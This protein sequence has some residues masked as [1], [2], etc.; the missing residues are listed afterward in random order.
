VN[1]PLVIELPLCAV[2]LVVAVPVTFLFM[3]VLLAV[4]RKS[5][6][7]PQSGER[8]RLAILM[9]AHNE[10]LLV[11]SSIG[12]ILPQLGR[13]DRLVVVADNCSDDTAAIAKSAGAEVLVRTD[14]SH[15]GKGYALDYG[16]RHLE[17]DPPD[18]VIIVDA[19]CQAA[20]GCVDRLARLCSRTGRPIQALYLMRAPTGSRIKARVAEFAWAVINQIRPTGLNR[21]GLPC[22]LMGSGMAFPWACISRAAVAS[23]HLVEDRILGIDLARGGFPPLFCPDALV[24]SYFPVSKEGTRSQR[25]RWEH[26]SLGNIVGIALPLFLRSLFPFNANLMAMALDMAVPPLALLT[27]QVVAIW[28]AAALYFAFTGLL[29]PLAI[30]TVIGALLAFSIVS[31][32]SR[33]ARHI[34]SLGDLALAVGYALA[35]IP[36]YAKFLRVRQSEWIRSKRDSDERPPP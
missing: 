25:T 13:F 17:R 22:Q 28:C 6:V 1:L 18:I 24:T 34:I 29:V 10:A 16:I 33:Y 26:G 3:E 8:R 15:R 14:T 32:W 5:A 27:L 20:V 19:D 31:S 21:L 35:K 36:L 2:A 12:S 11:A 23:G 30:S 9:P 7:A 4:T